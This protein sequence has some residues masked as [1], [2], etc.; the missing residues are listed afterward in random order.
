MSSSA[1]RPDGE[2]RALLDGELPSAHAAEVRQHLAACPACHAR[3]TES[4]QADQ[5]TAGLLGLLEPPPAASLQLDTVLHR[6]RRT[7]GRRT[8][9]IAAAVTLMVTAAAGATV[10]RPFVRTLAARVWAAVH[11]QGRAPVQPE[12]PFG[13]QTGVAVVPG[14]VAEIVFDT[15][16][17][18]GVLR[19]SLADTSELAIRSS[20]PVMYRVTPG[21]VR[22]HNRG[23][24]ASYEV[25]IPRSAR[26]VRI[27]IASRVM[28]EKTGLRVVAATSADSAGQYVMTI[29]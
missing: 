27:V 21:G 6:A 1:H 4:E 15:T 14:D 8:A 2:L 12:A 29:Q 22:V 5:T 16:Q 17:A 11:P 28:F 3:L 19:V 23:S 10:G 25:I 7:R 18:G 13:A 24:A 20:A 26:S 9:L